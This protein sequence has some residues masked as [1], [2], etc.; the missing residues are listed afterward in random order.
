[1]TI[2]MQREGPEPR[3]ADVHPDMV[4]DYRKAGFAPV[5]PLDHDGGR[6]LLDR[7]VGKRRKGKAK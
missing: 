5:D 6:S 1:M 2:R 4:D 7:R 3:F